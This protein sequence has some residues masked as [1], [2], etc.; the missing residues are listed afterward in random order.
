M[1]QR[2]ALSQ[3]PGNTGI[4]SVAC[5]TA[6]SIYLLNRYLTCCSMVD[7]EFYL[8]YINKG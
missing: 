1:A 3:Y 4:S 7:C 8:Y 5:R 6:R 2:C